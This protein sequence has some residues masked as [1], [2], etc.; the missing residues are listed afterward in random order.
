MAISFNGSTDYLEATYSMSYPFT[1]AVWFRPS[2][3]TLSGNMLAAGNVAGT[4]NDVM[5]LQAAGATSG[6]PVRLFLTVDGGNT[7]STD[8]TTGYS[9]NVWQHAAATG[10]S[11]SNRAVYLNGGS[12]ATSAVSRGMTGL[13]CL[14]LGARRSGGVITAFYV[15]QLAEAAVWSLALSDDEIL[16]LSRGVAPESIRPNSLRFYAPLVRD[17]KDV[18]GAPFTI[19]GTSVAEHPRIFR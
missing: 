9:A 12:K 1:M 11:A 16:Q 5:A 10:L 6:D 18:Y 17:I 4:D 8:T 19:N 13:D 15:G 3:T 7:T 14:T 2:S